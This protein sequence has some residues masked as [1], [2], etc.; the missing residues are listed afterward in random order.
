V[1]ATRAF[2]HSSIGSY[3]RRHGVD[4]NGLAVGDDFGGL[5][6][7]AEEAASALGD[8]DLGVHAALE[9]VLLP[10]VEAAPGPVAAVAGEPAPGPLTVAEALERFC[11]ASAE[12]DPR[13]RFTVEIADT[14]AVL[15]LRV[16]ASARPIGRHASELLMVAALG[17]V[18]AIAGR[19]GVPRRAWTSSP[20]PPDVSALAAAL[21]GAAL[22]FRAPDTGF[23]LEPDVL[24]APVVAP[25]RVPAATGGDLVG[26]MRALLRPT[27]RDGAAPV[28]SLARALAMSTRTLQRRLL[29]L[30]TTYAEVLDD[31]RRDHARLHLERRGVSVAS[32][33]RQVGYSDSRAFIRAFRRWTG[34]TP[35][36]YRLAG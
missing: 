31:L 6:A 16:P 25:E 29:G 20:P 12:G 23:I 26:D 35:G 9:E 10:A 14:G 33:A 22:A 27:L 21:G 1:L 18:R 34:G 15:A 7:F 32:A 3:L 11:A 24:R 36:T 5:A 13:V 28:T 30:G 17:W 2:A 19:L 4:A 8:P